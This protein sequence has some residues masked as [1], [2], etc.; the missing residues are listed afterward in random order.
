MPRE[1]QIAAAAKLVK[2]VSRFGLGRSLVRSAQRLP[3]AA[4][5]YRAL[6][7]YRRPFAT[8]E[9]ARAAVASFPAQGHEGLTNVRHHLELAAQAR[10]SD[11]AALFHIR[12]LLPRLTSVFDLGGN[13]GNLF[14]C[15]SRY[16]D[17]PSSLRWTVQD[18]PANMAAGEQIARERGATAL[19]F[20]GNW[21]DASGVGLLLVSGSLHYLEQPLPEMV[22]QLTAPPAYIL[23]NRTP[24][25]EGSPTAAVQAASGFRLA[26]RLYN[27]TALLN[28]LF[29]LG[30]ELIDEWKAAELS[31]EIPGYP[32]FSVP[33]YSGAFLRL[34]PNGAAH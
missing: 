2:G 4:P 10:P 31:M 29:A 19:H 17:L 1:R 16:L 18:L 5:L 20:T 33:A 26:C 8:L 24:L 3:V 32:E 25:V 23:I 7:G 27:R 30:Y 12:P 28:D 6:L 11:Y 34:K 9:E 21:Q 14:Y 22:A 15:Y 13:A